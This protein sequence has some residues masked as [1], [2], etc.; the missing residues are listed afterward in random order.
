MFPEAPG[1]GKVWPWLTAGAHVPAS[2]T[3]VPAGRALRGTEGPRGVCVLTQGAER[4]RRAV[5][6]WA[7][8]FLLLLCLLSPPFLTGSKV[9]P[10]PRAWRPPGCGGWRD[11]PGGWVSG[12]VPR[13]GVERVGA[14]PF[15]CGHL[16][17]PGPSRPRWPAARRWAR[18]QPEPSTGPRALGC[19]D[20]ASGCA[21]CVALDVV[22]V[23]VRP[24]QV[25]PPR[26]PNPE[27]GTRNQAEQRARAPRAALVVQ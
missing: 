21:L 13:A 15:L 18:S 1:P 3:A 26:T 4:E 24:S 22:S 9:G 7:R 27:S 12:A 2:H 16:L 23:L 14:H 6:A 20:P 10:R 19:R 17:T 11:R 5:G 25:S 8:C